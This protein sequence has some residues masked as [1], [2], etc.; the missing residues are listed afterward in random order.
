MHNATGQQPLT[1]VSPNSNLTTVRQK[2]Y[3]SVNTMSFHSVIHVHY[4]L[5]HLCCKSLWFPIKGKRS[6]GFLADIPQCSNGVE[7]CKQTQN[8]S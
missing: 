2:R 5:H 1:S 3:S 6:N 8:V 7:W 4:S